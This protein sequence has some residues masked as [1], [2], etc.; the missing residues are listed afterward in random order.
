MPKSIR[1]G[2]GPMT[3]AKERLE[4]KK[5]ITAIGRWYRVGGSYDRIVEVADWTY[6]TKAA[7]LPKEVKD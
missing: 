5:L 3:P 1:G 7:S 6:A 2:T 4:E